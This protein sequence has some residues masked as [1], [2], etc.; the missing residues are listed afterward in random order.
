MYVSHF[1]QYQISYL[2]TTVKKNWNPNFLK[3]HVFYSA[4]GLTMTC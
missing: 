4:G 3:T 1:I 2:F